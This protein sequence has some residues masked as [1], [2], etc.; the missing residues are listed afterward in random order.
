MNDLSVEAIQKELS[1]RETEELMGIWEEH[2]ISQWTDN[3]FKA[4]SN[5][6]TERL[7][8]PPRYEETEAVNKFIDEA[9][10]FL[11]IEELY[12]ALDKTNQAIELA[13]QYGYTYFVRGEIFDEMNKPEQAI[14]WYEEALRLSPDLKEAKRYLSWAMKEVSE[15][16]IHSDE[17]ILAAISHLGIIG[18]V[19]GIL[20]PAIV[21]I[22]H[23]EKSYYVAY[24]SLQAIIYQIFVACVQIVIA[25][26]T[27]FQTI[28]RSIGNPQLQVML[29]ALSLTLTYLA[30]PYFI[31]WIYGLIGV[32][33]TF[34]GKPFEYVGI[35]KLAHKVRL[36]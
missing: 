24:Q 26:L 14:K 11:E 17:R 27:A 10:A 31:F 15:K 16:N 29:S 23:H 9:E 12:K 28:A 4:I 18:G 8:E 35:G 32:I 1:L 25:L 22:S 33:S 7:G 13:P 20:I 5:I 2:D 21:W 3:A 34:R 6:L 36:P 19:V 30:L